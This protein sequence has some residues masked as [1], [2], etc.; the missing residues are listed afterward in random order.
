M[1]EGNQGGQ[2]PNETPGS[3]TTLNNDELEQDV[4]IQ[5]DEL[6]VL[7]EDTSKKIKTAIAQKKHWRTKAEKANE[8]FEAYK[9]AN[10][11]KEVKPEEKPKEKSKPGEFTKEELKEELSLETKYPLLT[12]VDM[13]RAKRDAEEEGKTLTEV[14][15]SDHYQAVLTG[16]EE[17]K[18]REENTPA[19]S[20]RS[21]DAP[22]NDITS[23]KKAVDNPELIR[24]MDEKTYKKFVE[25]DEKRGS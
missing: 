8:E 3:D 14:I 23:F 16:R 24:G 6:E 21:G 4:D 9:E 13:R 11:A 18:Q 7:E 10:P 17:Q 2:D 20:D 1:T 15:E 5:D 19:P 22:N 12:D 25:W